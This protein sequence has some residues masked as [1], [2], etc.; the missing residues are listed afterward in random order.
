MNI[1][2][3]GGG[4]CGLAT[5]LALRQAGHDVGVFERAPELKEVCTMFPSFP[6]CQSHRD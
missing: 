6:P 3:I 1:L 2:I 5:A 4:L